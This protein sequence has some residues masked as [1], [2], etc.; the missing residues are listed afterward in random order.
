MYSTTS[1]PIEAE[2]VFFYKRKLNIFCKIYIFKFYETK[3]LCKNGNNIVVIIHCKNWILARVH[4]TRHA[5]RFNRFDSSWST[6]FWPDYT[7]YAMQLDPIGLILL[8]QLL[9]RNNTVFWNVTPC[10]LVEILLTYLRN[11]QSLSLW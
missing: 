3:I 11:F 2:F 6:S 1:G 4:K 9:F 10:S 5:A 7:K 8:G